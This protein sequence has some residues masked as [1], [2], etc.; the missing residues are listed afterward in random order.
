M[1]KTLT[2]TATIT[3]W[4][5]LLSLISIPISYGLGTIKSVKEVYIDLK[6]KSGSID[7]AFKK[8]EA[9][10]DFEFH[11]DKSNIKTD[12]TIQ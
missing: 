2:K 4:S 12:A 1:K 3:L 5:V 8:I 7:E 9:K 11:Y 10:T 6:L